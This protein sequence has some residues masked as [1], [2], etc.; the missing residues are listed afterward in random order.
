MSTPLTPEPRRGGPP[1]VNDIET[2]A[3]R[4]A[5]LPGETP[6]PPYGQSPYGQSPYGPSA[7]GQLPYGGPVP[8]QESYY[9]MT[10]GYEQGP[11]GFA[12]L[13]QM[14][15]VGMLN[16]EQMVRTAQSGYFPAKLV[17]GLFSRRDYTTALLLS[18]FLGLLGVDR[19]YL[20]STEIGL[21]KLFSLG[22]LGFWWVI[23]F[24]LLATRSLTDGDGRPLA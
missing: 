13:Q 19:F 10:I 4:S 11:V 20:G 9:V 12:Q 18:F 14:V 2:H 17:P 3:L 22:G 7:Y 16:A 24:V 1:P 21:L 15:T 23:D 5:D 6:A 8:G